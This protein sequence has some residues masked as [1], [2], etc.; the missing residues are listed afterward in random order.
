MIRSLLQEGTKGNRQFRD[1][2]GEKALEVLLREQVDH[3]IKHF[4]RYTERG[5]LRAVGKLRVDSVL[6][7]WRGSIPIE[8]KD[9]AQH[10]FVAKQVD[11]AAEN[12]LHTQGEG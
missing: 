8:A 1:M 6:E 7:S 2:L 10:L 9:G 3:L 5:E 4:R 11:R 12:R